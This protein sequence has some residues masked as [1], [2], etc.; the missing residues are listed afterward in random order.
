MLTGPSFF[1]IATELRGQFSYY[2]FHYI[3]QAGL[4][5]RLPVLSPPD[6][7][8]VGEVPKL[9]MMGRVIPTNLKLIIRFKPVV[10]VVQEFIALPLLSYPEIRVIREVDNDLHVLIFDL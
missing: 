8:V 4:E 2:Y 5:R 9:F 6:M 7:F 1:A 10:A 3:C